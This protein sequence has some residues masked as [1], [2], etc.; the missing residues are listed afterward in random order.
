MYIYNMIIL[1]SYTKETTN[2]VTALSI[3]K[4]SVSLCLSCHL[5]KGKENQLLFAVNFKIPWKT[6][7]PCCKQW[8]ISSKQDILWVGTVF[9]ENLPFW[10]P[11]NS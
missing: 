4:I 7:Q 3:H 9:Q 6:V 8:V 1:Y 11:T 10:Y 5:C 2:A